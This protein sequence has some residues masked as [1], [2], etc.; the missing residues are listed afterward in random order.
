MDRQIE[1]VRAYGTD[2]G[3]LLDSVLSE[4]LAD[5]ADGETL[6]VPVAPAAAVR[7]VPRVRALAELVGN[8]PFVAEAFHHRPD[9]FSA[10]QRSLAPVPLAHLEFAKDETY[11]D[12]IVAAGYL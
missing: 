8:L 2:A 3:Q 9:L 5:W 11:W 10:I 12:A 6:V 7:E 1:A 4:I